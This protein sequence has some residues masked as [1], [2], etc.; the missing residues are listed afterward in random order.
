M[1]AN[2][3]LGVGLS[4][5]VGFAGMAALRADND[6]GESNDSE[7]RSQIGLAYVRAQGIQLN[8]KGRDRSQ[9]GLGSY[10]VNAV[11]G[12]NDCHTAPPY[13]MDPY[14]FLGAPKQVNVACYLAGGQAFGPFVSRDI[15]PWEKGKPAGL[16]FRQFLHV[17]R[18]GEDPDKPG[19]VL[20]VMPWPVYQTMTD[21]DLRAMYEYLSSIPA[22]DANICGV[23]SE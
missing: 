13:T 2:L 7:A 11:G 9:V 15:T 21:G 12:C 4:I 3:I 19:Q 1:R 14:A 23:P 8:L 22:I 20:Q 16:T 5:F 18:T 10:L 17:M 6:R